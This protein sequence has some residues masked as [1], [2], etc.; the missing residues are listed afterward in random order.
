MCGFG[1]RRRSTGVGVE[2]FKLKWL[3]ELWFGMRERQGMRFIAPRDSSFAF[4]RALKSKAVVIIPLDHSPGRRL[5][6]AP[7]SL[8]VKQVRRLAPQ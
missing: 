1:A 5:A 8:G 3:N 7:N 4:L 2:I 6:C